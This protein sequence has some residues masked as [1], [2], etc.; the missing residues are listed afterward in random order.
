MLDPGA[1]RERISLQSKVITQD[2]TGAPV[3]TWS[4]IAALWAAKEPLSGREFFDAQGVFEE[5]IV[6][7]RIRYREG[8]DPAMRIAHGGRTYNIKSIIDPEERHR[9]LE[10]LCAEG[11]SDGG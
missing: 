6:R 1:L 4:E 11:V 2:S 5:N 3:E 10:L 9:E 8:M 7:F